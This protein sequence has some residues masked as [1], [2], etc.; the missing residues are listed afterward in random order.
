MLMMFS[1][2]SLDWYTKYVSRW[3]GGAMF[4]VLAIAVIAGIAANVVPDDDFLLAGHTVPERAIGVATMV[5]YIHA[6]R[7][8][9][10]DL[11]HT[12]GRSLQLS[13][14]QVGLHSCEAQVRAYRRDYGKLLRELNSKCPAK[15]AMVSRLE[16]R[17]GKLMDANQC[18]E[19]KARVTDIKTRGMP[20]SFFLKSCTSV[21]GTGDMIDPHARKG[22]VGHFNFVWLRSGL[23]MSCKVAEIDP[24]GKWIWEK[25]KR[26]GK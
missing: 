5:P 17:L 15:K 10:D 6:H 25:P 4:V 16:K 13:G 22:E 11:W 26:A 2:G 19:T 1:Q 18:A 20:R 12:T 9:E 14:A 7:V 3:I 8:C 23:Y 24:G 21:G